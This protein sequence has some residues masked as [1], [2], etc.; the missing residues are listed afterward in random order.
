MQLRTIWGNNKRKICIWKGNARAEKAV[1][2]SENVNLSP[3]LNGRYNQRP[4]KNNASFDDCREYSIVPTS[5]VPSWRTL[6]K[7]KF[8]YK[9]QVKHPADQQ[10][11]S[12]S[13]WVEI[14]VKCHFMYDLF[15]SEPFFEHFYNNWATPCSCSI[16]PFFS[17]L[18]WNSFQHFGCNVQIWA[19]DINS[20]FSL[21]CWFSVFVLPC[22]HGPR[23]QFHHSS[24]KRR[25]MG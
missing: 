15:V 3:D 7:L 21:S 18:C 25:L 24:L 17:P 12:P 9:I 19:G 2:K 22:A 6:S 20:S 13:N 5:G 10:W 11:F 1:Q 4:S 14:S 8:T 16:I 23:V